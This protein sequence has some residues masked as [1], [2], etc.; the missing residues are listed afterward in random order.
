MSRMKIIEK[1]STGD[2]KRRWKSHQTAVRSYD[3]EA[4]GNKNGIVLITG[5]RVI[6]T[7]KNIGKYISDVRITN[8][9]TYGR[10]RRY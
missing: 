1:G 5:E 2:T 10:F 4:D 3:Y 9:S 7:A 6:F 8:R